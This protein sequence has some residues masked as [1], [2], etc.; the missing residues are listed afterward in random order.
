VKFS[1]RGTRRIVFIKIRNF[2][3]WAMPKLFNFR[4]PEGW[5]FP[6]CDNTELKRSSWICFC[7]RTASLVGG[8][9]TF[10]H[11]AQQNFLLILEIQVLGAQKSKVVGASP[12]LHF[13]EWKCWG[14]ISEHLASTAAIYGPQFGRFMNSLFAKIYWKKVTRV[15]S[16]FVH[17]IYGLARFVGNQIKMEGWGP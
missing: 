5:Y 16:N 11:P 7:F 13:A 6:I 12:K 14:I 10:Q 15:C 4:F 9:L 17:K 8:G 2:K 3:L 1:V